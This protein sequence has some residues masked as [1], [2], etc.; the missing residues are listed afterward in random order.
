MP[1]GA[2][3]H[4]Q[5]LRVWSRPMNGT[6]LRESCYRDVSADHW[7]SSIRNDDGRPSGTNH[8]P[9]PAPGSKQSMSQSVLAHYDIV[10]A[11][12]RRSFTG[13]ETGGMR[14]ER[15]DART[16]PHRDGAV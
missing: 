15:H 8:R 7:P 13:E 11:I 6:N 1:L 16:S 9:V 3:E 14:S 4:A 2:T 10:S 5:E 12:V